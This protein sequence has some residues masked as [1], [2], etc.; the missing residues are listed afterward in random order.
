M[1][2]SEARHVSCLHLLPC[3]HASQSGGRFYVFFMRTSSS[4]YHIVLLHAWHDATR[5]TLNQPWWIIALVFFFYYY[6][7]THSHGSIMR[8]SLIWIMHLFFLFPSNQLCLCHLRISQ[9]ITA[10]VFTAKC[11]LTD[12]TARLTYWGDLNCLHLHPSIQAVAAS[13]QNKKLNAI[14]FPT[15]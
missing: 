1:C 12:H 14:R 3:G 13:G 7:F 10:V 9:T 5:L 11:D 6:L 8:L 2:S 15:G 4:S